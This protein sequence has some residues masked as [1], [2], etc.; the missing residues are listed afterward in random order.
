MK[1]ISV[2]RQSIY[3][4]ILSLVLLI[5]VL[6]FSFLLL[7]PEG[8]NYRVQRT[9]L[10]KIDKEVSQYENFKDETLTKLKKLQSDNH[11]VIIAFSTSFSKE[12]FQKLYSKYFTSLDISKSSKVIE[13]DGFLTYD[14]NTTSKINSPKSF[15]NFL[16]A[17][18]KSDWIVSVNFPIN[19]KRENEVI[20]SSFSMKVY[21]NKDKK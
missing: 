20:R 9:Q 7:I 2:S 15:Y 14:I 19:F 1:K 21:K 18:N 5:F 16:D 17:I 12:K 4:L 13:E 3:I 10:R 11:K 6:L 8:K